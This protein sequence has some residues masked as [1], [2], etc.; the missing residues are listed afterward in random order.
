[1]FFYT[2]VNEVKLAADENGMFRFYFSVRYRYNID[3]RY[4]VKNIVKGCHLKMRQQSFME[5]M[6]RYSNALAENGSKASARVGKLQRCSVI[7]RHHETLG[8]NAFDDSVIAEYIREISDRFNK[9]EIGED[10]ANAMRRETEQFIHFVKTGDVR[11]TNPLLGARTILLTDFQR[12]VDGFLSSEVAMIGAG[13]RATSPNTRS[14]MRWVVHKYFEWL[15]TQ[16]FASLR[17]VGAEQIQ[18]FLLHCT[19]TMAMGSVHNVRL[20][21]LKL[22]AYLYKFGQSHSSFTELLSFKVNRGKKVTE[23]HSANEL[24]AMLEVIDRRTIDGKR[25]YAVS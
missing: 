14:D 18:M 20:F 6:E 10:H 24:T 5:L 19:E 16:G 1:M 2:L 13:G 11:M 23:T 3:D 4:T 7:I 15:T 22:Y 17:R 21:L 12:I 9:G 25:A 8:K